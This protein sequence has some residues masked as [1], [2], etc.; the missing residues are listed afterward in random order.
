[1]PL[2][3]KLGRTGVR[4]IPALMAKS[5]RYTLIT[6]IQITR[7]AYRSGAVSSEMKIEATS[8]VQPII[9]KFIP[10]IAEP[11]TMNGRRRPKS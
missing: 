6:A 5:R 2:A 8:F 4:G 11:A 7:V 9:I 3:L 10:T 1:M